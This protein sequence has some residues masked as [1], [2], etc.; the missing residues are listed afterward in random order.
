MPG[1]GSMGWADLTGG[2]LRLR[3]R[4]MLVGAQGVPTLLELAWIRLGQGGVDLSP[5]GDIIRYVEDHIEHVLDK[6]PLARSAESLCREVSG[7]W[8]LDHCYRTFAFALL[9]GAGRANDPEKLFAMAM[10]H[11][12]GLTDAFRQGSNPDLGPTY[13]RAEAPCFA[14]RG[15]GVAESLA[16]QTGSDIGRGVAE[17]CR[18]A[19]VFSLTEPITPGFPYTE[20]PPESRLV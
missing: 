8:L 18:G 2:E 7:Q 4:A 11:D 14:V 15:A 17:A 1:V 13:A 12:I 10:L 5:F 9:L 19:V 3:D 6:S 16:E 20:R